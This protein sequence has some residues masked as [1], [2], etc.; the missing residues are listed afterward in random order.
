MFSRRVLMAEKRLS[1]MLFLQAPGR[2]W[3]TCEELGMKFPVCLD[4][5]QSCSQG[6]SF[7]SNALHFGKIRCVT[8]LGR[9]QTLEMYDLFLYL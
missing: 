5:T 3:E 2:C 8:I 7:Y 4:S 1:P 6:A 9:Q